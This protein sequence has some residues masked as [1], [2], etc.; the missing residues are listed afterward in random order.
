MIPHWLLIELSQLDGITF[1]TQEVDFSSRAQK[2]EEY[3][4]INPKGVVPTLVIHNDDGSSSSYTESAAIALLLAA[5]HPQANL[6]PHNVQSPQYA[7]YIETMIYLAN[8]VLPAMRDWFYASSDS[9][10]SS[11]STIKTIKQMATR[12]IGAAWDLLD[13][14]LQDQPYLVE[15]VVGGEWQPTA[16]DFL[17]VVLARWSRN[18]D[19]PAVKWNNLDGLIRRMTSRGSWVAL[20]ANQELEDAE[21]PQ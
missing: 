11:E 4:A 8:T 6:A 13:K 12:R 20:K 10:S 1:D 21:W 3:L 15:N 16:A 9:Q 2:S 5:R 14:Q 18:F 19:E 7:K 17:V